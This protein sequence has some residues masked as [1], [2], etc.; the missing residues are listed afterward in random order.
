M[1]TK[2]SKNVDRYSKIILRLIKTWGMGDR[3]EQINTII[4]RI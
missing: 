4:K 1:H 2:N 3:K